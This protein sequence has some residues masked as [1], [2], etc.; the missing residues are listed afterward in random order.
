MGL[1]REQLEIDAMN[2]TREHTK[3]NSDPVAESEWK[4]FH[5]IA[6]IKLVDGKGK[7]I[8]WVPVGLREQM[9]F[10]VKAINAHSK[11]V[12]FVK[13]LAA[14]KGSDHPDIPTIDVNI[15]TVALHLLKQ[16]GESND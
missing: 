12:E 13:T 7:Q 2:I 16:I 14:I 11:L 1:T 9:D 6:G 8:A 10:I 3:T 15:Q 4:A 5:T